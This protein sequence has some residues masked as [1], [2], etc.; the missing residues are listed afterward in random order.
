MHSPFAFCETDV[1]LL[2][3]IVNNTI[4]KKEMKGAWLQDETMEKLHFES[5]LFHRRGGGKKNHEDKF[6]VTVVGIQMQMNQI[7]NQIPSLSF[8]H[9]IYHKWRA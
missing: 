6:F 8:I 1:L 2:R 5:L 3:I 7:L 4:I 9:T